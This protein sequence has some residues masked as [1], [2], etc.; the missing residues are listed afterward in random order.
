MAP[1]RIYDALD[2]IASAT[3]VVDAIWSANVLWAET[4]HTT[5]EIV[6]ASPGWY[7]VLGYLPVGADLMDRIHPDDHPATVRAWESMVAGNPPMYGFANRWHSEASGRWQWLVWSAPV[8]WQDPVAADG[9][10][11]AVAIALDSNGVW[12]SALIDAAQRRRNGASDV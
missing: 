9:R 4:T 12:R 1:H 2:G 6:S 3:A 10:S 7:D 5:G 11:L 8:V